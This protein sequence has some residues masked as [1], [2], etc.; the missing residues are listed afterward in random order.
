MRARYF[1]AALIAHLRPRRAPAA[2]PPPRG[3]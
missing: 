1:A 2:V 3:A